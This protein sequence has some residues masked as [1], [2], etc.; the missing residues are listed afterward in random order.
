MTSTRTIDALLT[1]MDDT[2]MVTRRRIE[3]AEALL[4]FEAPDEAVSRAREFLMHVFEDKEEAIADRMDA[5]RASRKAES[6]KVAQKIVRL[7]VKKDTEADRREAWRQYE[8]SQLKMK[9]FQV[10]PPGTVFPPGWCDHLMGA[11][12]V[13]PVDEGWPP[14][15]KRETK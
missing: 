10:L 5:L 1:I 3:A 15:S 8:K 2:E 14:W 9:L 7:E 13:P 6:P 11:D 12:Y 4:D